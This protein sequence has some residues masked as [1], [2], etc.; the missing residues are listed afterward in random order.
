MSELTPQVRDQLFLADLGVA[1]PSGLEDCCNRGEV[2]QLPMCAIGS[3][4]SH[5]FPI[6][7]D[8]HHEP[9]RRGFKYPSWDEFIL[10]T[11][12]WSTLARVCVCV[13]VWSYGSHFCFLCEGY[14]QPGHRCNS[15]NWRE[16]S[17]ASP[18]IATKM[19]HWRVASMS[20]WVNKMTWNEI[21]NSLEKESAGSWKWWNPHMFKIPWG[22][23]AT[24][25]GLFS[26]RYRASQESLDVGRWWSKT[27]LV[28]CLGGGFKYLPDPRQRAP[29]KE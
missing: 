29:I 11:G 13:C 27:W 15:W 16:N 20:R 4:N 12:S 21:L 1:D 5:S 3:I 19:L 10:N 28:I 18:N 7:R 22:R 6:C 26:L 24:Q 25:W 17:A 14:F 23:H 8:V 9:H 2:V